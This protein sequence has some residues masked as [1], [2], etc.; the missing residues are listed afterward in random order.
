MQVYQERLQV[1]IVMLKKLNTFLVKHIFW[2]N[3]IKKTPI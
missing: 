1:G 3:N 2:P